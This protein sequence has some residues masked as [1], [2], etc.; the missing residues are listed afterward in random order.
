M[1]VAYLAESIIPSRTAN[2]I[3]V[4]RMCEAFANHG[5]EVTLFVP[6]RRDEREPGIT[7]VF[8]FYGVR[9]NFRIRFLAWPALPYGWIFTC[10]DFVLK[11]GRLRPDLIYARFLYGCI[12]P[13]LLGFKVTV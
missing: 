9:P 1:K 12:F 4:M 3:H 11:V 6:H 2:S 5:H 13:A 7:D 10:L 8:G